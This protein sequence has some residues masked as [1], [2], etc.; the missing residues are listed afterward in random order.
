MD[1]SSGVG[2]I[3]NL[4]YT[5]LLCS[6][7]EVMKDFYGDVMKFDLRRHI[8]GRYAE[9]AVGSSILALRLRTRTYDGATVALGSA[10]VQ[11]AF[12]VPPREVMMAADQLEDLGIEILEPVAD[13]EDFGHRTL[14]FADPENNVIEIY[15]EI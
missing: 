9:F 13:L 14:F 6:D 12:R 2:A 8:S 3:R 1:P 4:D 7:I 11:L 15:A 5:M 10:S